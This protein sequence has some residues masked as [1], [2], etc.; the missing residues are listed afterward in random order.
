[1]TEDAELLHCYAE[2]RSEDAFA[3][4][5]RRRIGLVY[6]VALRQT[7]DTHR[8]EDVAQAVFTDLARKAATLSRR[9]ILVGWLYRSAQFAATDVV[10]AEQSRARREKEAQIMQE[11]MGRDGPD[12][13]WEKVRPVLD[14][15]IGELNEHDRD[16]SLLRF[17]DGRQFADIGV[18]FQLSENGARMR[19][20]R[21]LDK[22]CG[23]LARR[24]IT[25][26]TAALGTILAQQATAATPAGLAAM[27]TGT[28]MASVSAVVPPVIGVLQL[29]TTTKMAT[30]VAGVALMILAVGT[31]TYE[32]QSRRAAEASLASASHDH[33]LLLA[34]LNGLEESVRTAE[35]DAAQIKKRVDD[36]RTAAA[37]KGAADAQAAKDGAAWDPLAEGK[38]FLRR[39]PEVRQAPTVRMPHLI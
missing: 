35:Q 4:L 11:T 39:H 33:Q 2:G 36:A 23:L 1:M 10:R 34:K 29:M 25:S 26:T 24:G 14:Q 31:A 20:D 38:A 30:G 19:V 17:F 8:A 13:E 18:R 37:A 16:A 21:A 12:P 7:R 9:P 27:V 28:A 15:V 3:E 32:H 6:S 22:L 5:V